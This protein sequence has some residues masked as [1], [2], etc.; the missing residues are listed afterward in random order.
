M[1]RCCD[2]H[3]CPHCLRC[4]F[5]VVIWDDLVDPAAHER[6]IHPLRQLWNDAKAN[7]RPANVRNGR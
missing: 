2:S 6:A 3:T 4:L 1:T 5:H 7:V